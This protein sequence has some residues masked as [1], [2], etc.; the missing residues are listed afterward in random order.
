MV[1][2]KVCELDKDIGNFTKHR[3]SKDGKVGTCI[4]CIAELMPDTRKCIKCN[5]T[6]SMTEF[7]KNARNMFGKNTICIPCYKAKMD[8]H[9]EENVEAIKASKKAYRELH[10]VNKAKQDKEYREA[11]R[12]AIA[13]RKKMYSASDS[14]KKVKERGR[15]KRELLIRETRDGS[16]NSVSLRELYEEQNGNCY[17]CGCDLTQLKKRNVHM[18]H[19]IPLTKGG[20]HILENVAW[21]CASCNLSK[22]SK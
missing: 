1:Y 12:E 6:K 14:G 5:E 22:G 20:K 16:I 19:I 7:G 10:K 17:L 3:V 8:K 4:N 13:H 2:C 9:Q 11:N 15:L 21:S 18:D